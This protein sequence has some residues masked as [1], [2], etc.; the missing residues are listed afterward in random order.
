MLSQTYE[1]ISHSLT[2]WK[3]GFDSMLKNRVGTYQKLLIS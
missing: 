1:Q 3:P 2:Y